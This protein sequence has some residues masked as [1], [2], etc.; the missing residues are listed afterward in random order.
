[1][2]QPYQMEFGTIPLQEVANHE[3]PMPDKYIN[4]LGMD[5]TKAFLEYAKPLVGNLPEYFSLPRR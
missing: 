5:V 1:P 3:R 4:K 2:D